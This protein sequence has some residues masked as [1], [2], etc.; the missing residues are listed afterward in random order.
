MKSDLL[1]LCFVHHCRQISVCWY[2]FLGPTFFTSWRKAT[3]FVFVWSIIFLNVLCICCSVIRTAGYLILYFNEEEFFYC[4]ALCSFVIRENR[5]QCCNCWTSCLRSVGI[6]CYQWHIFVKL[7]VIGF[8]Y[9]SR[10]HSVCSENF[11]G[12]AAVVYCGWPLTLLL[13]LFI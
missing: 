6:P 12:M 1:L 5:C 2:A 4:V 10:F 11:F 7:C 9:W 8:A 3:N 13:Y